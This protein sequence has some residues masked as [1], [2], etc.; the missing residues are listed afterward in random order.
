MFNH[1][2][3]EIQNI[4]HLGIIAGIID[5]I[6]LVDIINELIGQEAQEK[7]SPGHVVKAMI[8]NGL[9]FVSSPLYMFPEFFKDKPCEHLIGEG[10]K[11]EYLNDDKLGRV[12]DKLFIKGLTEIFLEITINV[13][14]KFNISLKS[15]HLDS[16]SLHLHGEYNT[17]LP[18]VIIHNNSS[19]GQINSPQAIEITYGYS[20]DHR[21][22]LKQFI[23][24]LISSSDGDIPIFLKS[25]SGNQSDSSSFANIF[26]EYKEQMQKPEIKNEDSLMV[27]DAALYNAKNISSLFGTRWLSRVPMTIG[28]A[29]ELVSTLLSTNF[30]S[31]SLTGYYYSV[32]KSNYGGIE[33]R[34]LVVESTERKESD[35]R[36]L[37][38]RISKSK[39][40]AL[41]HLKK[42]LD[43]KFNSRDCAIKAVENFKKKFKYH[44]I[45]NIDYLEKESKDKQVFY[46]LN[47]SLSENIHAIKIAYQGAGRFILATNILDEKSLSNDDMLSEYKAQQSCERGF[48]FLKDPLFFA[49]SIFLKSPERI[50]AMAMIMGLC[51]LVYTLA[52]RQIRKA[53]SA[54][55]STIKNQLGKSINNPTMRWIFQCFQSIHLVKFDNEISISN[56]NSEREYI[57]S[58]LPENCRYYYKC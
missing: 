27:A 51:L 47:A 33:Q 52:Q 48:G 9:G 32:V 44:Q 29:K 46:Q 54:S 22:D 24:D 12:M 5:A 45:D 21:P 56:L 34:W 35:L 20:R 50:E 11:A 25:A 4:D 57:L 15:S 19:N 6:G 37:E 58:F 26:L 10:V 23:I 30:I 18:D 7:V 28:L 36:K 13:I 2:E 3:I 41:E 1:Q 53:L 43:S 49:D 40:S 16:T 39:T 38:K 14:Q 42:L 55:E 31:S 17:S 8:L